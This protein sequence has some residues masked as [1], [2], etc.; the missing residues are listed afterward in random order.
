MSTGICRIADRKPIFLFR[1]ELITNFVEQRFNI[2]NIKT[3]FPTAL[4]AITLSAAAAEPERF[5][6]SGHVSNVPD[7]TV[8]ELCRADGN[9]LKTIATD[10]ISGG[11]IHFSDTISGPRQKYLLAGESRGLPS[12]LTAIWVESGADITV[13]GDGILYPLW[14]IISTIPEQASESALIKST[15]P[16]F[17][18]YL[19]LQAE[20]TELIKHF[21][22]DLKGAPEHEAATWS[23]IDSIRTMSAPLDSVM[24]FKKLAFMGSAPID[25]VWLDEFA[26]YARAVYT[27]PDYELR[28]PVMAIYG[29]LT[30]EILETESGKIIK[31]Y[32]TMDGIIDA[33]DRMADGTLYDPQGN[34]HTLAEF[35]GKRHILLDFWSRGCGPCIASMPEAEEVAAQY[36][37]RLAFISISSDNEAD[38][39]DFIAGKV[40][41]VIHLNELNDGRPGLAGR[42]GAFSIPHYV[43]IAPDGT[44]QAKWSGYGPGSLHQ[45]LSELLK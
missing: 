38:W 45:Q 10:T 12:W 14:D 33:D 27:D 31:D 23:R 36:A 7:S 41:K 32:L 2:M 1:E 37:D 44:V 9:L 39:K 19:R 16:E 40:D 13:S 43:L 42:Y 8:L 28:E 17:A 26:D 4:A 30:P 35:A 6:I 34:A 21:Y 11:R 5:T 18:E 22:I 24:R 15:L 25:R 3:F 29:R 20:E